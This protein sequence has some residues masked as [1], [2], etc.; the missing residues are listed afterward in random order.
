MPFNYDYCHSSGTGPAEQHDPQQQVE[1][2]VSQHSGEFRDCSLPTRSYYCCILGSASEKDG[3]PCT[4][5]PVINASHWSCCGRRDKDAPC[6]MASG[7]APRQHSFAISSCRI[8]RKCSTCSGYGP[9]CCRVTETDRSQDK[10]QACGCGSGCSGCLNCGLCR[11]CCKA[12]PTSS[13]QSSCRGP[14]HLVVGDKIWAEW[15]KNGGTIYRGTIAASRVN[16]ETGSGSYDVRY[17]DGD[18]DQCVNPIRVHLVAPASARDPGQ[19]LSQLLSALSSDSSASEQA[20]LPILLGQTRGIRELLLGLSSGSLSSGETKKE[21][22]PSTPQQQQ[23]QQ[24]QGGHEF[25]VLVA[26]EMLDQLSSKLLLLPGQGCHGGRGL[27]ADYD[28]MSE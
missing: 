1:Q 20:S 5:G 4:H 6:G 13:P 3:V 9:K 27:F 21:P 2:V 19:R 11:A 28:P 25:E 22:L 26:S 14:L 12:A 7:E 8:C 17:D 16:P 15:K 24:Q 18:F 23:Q 10:G